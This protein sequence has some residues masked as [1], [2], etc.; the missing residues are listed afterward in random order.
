MQRGEHHQMH[1]QYNLG[2]QYQ[3]VPSVHL[4]WYLSCN[5]ERFPYWFGKRDPRNLDLLQAFPALAR[6][7]AKVPQVYSVPSPVERVFPTER[8]TDPQDKTQCL[9]VAYIKDPFALDT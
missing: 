4:P 7:V 5:R 3:V 8:I 1:H 2:Y 6:S 9:N